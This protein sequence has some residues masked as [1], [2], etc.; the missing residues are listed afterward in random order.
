MTLCVSPSLPSPAPHPKINNSTLH[1]VHIVIL[2][3]R[4]EVALERKK[5]PENIIA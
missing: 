5:D 1:L 3:V 2:N 4:K